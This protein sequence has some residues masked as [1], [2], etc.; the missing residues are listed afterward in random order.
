MLSDLL[1]KQ[2]EI[3]RMDES[4]EGTVIQVVDPAQPPERKSKP[5]RV[6]IAV[7]AT[8]ASGFVLLLYV[9]IRQAIRNAAQQPERAA[10]LQQL[11]AAWKR[12]LGRGA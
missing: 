4:R 5:K 6:L 9:F 8:V 10:K 1:A 7:L 11:H 12:A 3:A 2:Y